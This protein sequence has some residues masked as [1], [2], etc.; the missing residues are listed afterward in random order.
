MKF[1]KL[2]KMEID[3]K[4]RGFLVLLA[5]N[6]LPNVASS[7][8]GIDAG[9]QYMMEFEKSAKAN[10]EG[11]GSSIYSK[12]EG[13]HFVSNKEIPKSVKNE[14]R[15]IKNRDR[16]GRGPSSGF[17]FKI[18]KRSTIYAI[19]SN[20]WERDQKFLYILMDEKS[21]KATQLIFP[22]DIAQDEGVMGNSYFSDSSKT[23]LLKVSHSHFSE[24]RL[25][26]WDTHAFIFR[27]QGTGAESK[28]NPGFEEID[29]ELKLDAVTD[30]EGSSDWNVIK[31]V[32]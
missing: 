32:P 31:Y 20:V 24:S 11:I 13:K 26:Y 2:T 6:L 22:F 25:W 21:G 23:M 9:V 16:N 14:F 15:R 30:D 18:S 8:S 12:K 1:L 3:K 29:M 4:T 5:M 27:L 19:E 7:N 10:L 17:K 28:L